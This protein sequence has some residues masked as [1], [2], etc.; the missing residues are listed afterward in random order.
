MNGLMRKYLKITKRPL[1]GY[2]IFE[3]QV[4]IPKK[5]YLAMAL[6][7]LVLT[8]YLLESFGVVATEWIVLPYIGFLAL[9]LLGVPLLYIHRKKTGSVLLTH[10]AIAKQTFFRRYKLMFINNIR[11]VRQTRKNALIIKGKRRRFKIAMPI[12]P[13]D[14][15]VLKTLLSYEGHFKQKKKPY[16]LFFEGNDV[17]IQELAPSRDSVTSRLV[18]R[19]HDD[20]RHVTPGFI[21][22]VSFYNTEVSRVRHIDQK[23]VVFLLD[24]VDLKGDYPENTFYESMMTDNA[25]ALFQDVSHV[26]IFKIAKNGD[27]ELL[28]TSVA[29]L[30]KISR[31]ALVSETN[32]QQ[33]GERMSTD[34][35]L[36]QG[37]KK[38][39]V[40]FTFK[41]IIIGF[42]EL[43]KTAWFENS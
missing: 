13:H 42:N 4:K 2:K 16:K 33:S 11:K 31:G 18:E 23:H 36:M 15:N 40:R 19:F 32:F 3:K 9:V 35:V 1:A 43:K 6:F 7:F 27:I 12:Y 37:T 26:E 5:I 22:D 25:M 24:R 38:Q 34:M 8:Y 39:R 30:K 28:G 29:T 10:D 41:E 21:H 17:E 20:Y 14:I